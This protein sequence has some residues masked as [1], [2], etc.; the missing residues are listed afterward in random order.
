ML[1][2]HLHPSGP[3]LCQPS[4]RLRRSSQ[5]P[6]AHRCR[7]RNPRAAGFAVFY[8]PSN[9]YCGSG[10]GRSEELPHSPNLLLHTSILVWKRI[11]PSA[12]T[13]R[14]I[15]LKR[16]QLED[17]CMSSP[18]LI[19]GEWNLLQFPDKRDL[20][21]VGEQASVDNGLSMH[22]TPV[23]SIRRWIVM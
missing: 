10:F 4:L 23:T 2:L 12:F 18:L 5:F 8:Q 3:F 14:E 16:S 21:L 13:T 20:A 9:A 11:P 17:C 7:I 1:Q 6:L 15:S 22:L 19:D